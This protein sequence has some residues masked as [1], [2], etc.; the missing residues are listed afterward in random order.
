MVGL[1]RALRP[2]SIRQAETSLTSSATL[3]ILELANLVVR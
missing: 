2:V 3:G 1:L